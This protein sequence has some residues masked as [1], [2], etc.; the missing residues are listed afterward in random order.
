MDTPKWLRLK[1][2]KEKPGTIQCSLA[3][4]FTCETRRKPPPISCLWPRAITHRWRGSQTIARH[5]QMPRWPK[6]VSSG[7]FAFFPSACAWGIIAGRKTKFM[8]KLAILPELSKEGK[9]VY[10]GVEDARQPVAK[11]VG[12]REH[13][14]RRRSFDVFPSA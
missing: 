7:S 4:D 3:I 13:P 1:R 11:T 2:W 12:R 5:P 9:T 14:S 6:P 8:T 10:R